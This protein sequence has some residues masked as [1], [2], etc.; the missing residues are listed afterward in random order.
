[1]LR[2]AVLVPCYNEEHAIAHVV[3]GFRQALPAAVIYVYDNNSTDRTRELAAAA[4]AVVRTESRQGKGFVVRRMFSDIEAD[5]YVLV[6]G[7]HTY[8]A[9]VAPSMVD[10]LL[11]DRLDM[12]VG[13][14][15]S[16]ETAAYRTGH[17]LGNNMFASVVSMLFGER[18]GDL[19]S[20][21]R[22]FS[23]RFVKS[24]IVS[25]GGFEIEA[26]MTVHALTIHVPVREIDTV[27]R[28]RPNGSESKLN[29]YRDGIRILG[30]IVTLFREERPL[31]FFSLV[32]LF[33]IVLA[34]V[35]IY[36]VFIEFLRTHTVPR[37]PT[38]ILATGL[39]LSGLF[40]FASGLILDT[41]TRGRREAKTL[42]YLA[43]PLPVELPGE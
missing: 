10:T 32:G 41:V 40:S 29:T 31:T 16:T 43:I 37:F 24:F 35:L 5:A 15:I 4:G 11:K 20:G 36:P 19:L 26:E 14:R 18:F 22:V 34:L 8:D 27:Y 12:V 6:D 39:V 2:I 9:S 38:A 7:D 42:A 33:L 1:L 3:Q 21:Y 17:R 28:S 13:R 25:A 23:R 30:S